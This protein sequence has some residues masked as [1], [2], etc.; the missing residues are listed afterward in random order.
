[1]TDLEKPP[2]PTKSRGEQARSWT[3]IALAAAAVGAVIWFAVANSQRVSV[4]WFGIET[5][6]PLFLV[7]LL[8]ALLGAL[9][10]RAIRWR[11]S[12]RQ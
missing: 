1:M 3:R 5:D 6:S 12:R 2:Q 10:D 7:I 8:A 11:R 4:N 9:A